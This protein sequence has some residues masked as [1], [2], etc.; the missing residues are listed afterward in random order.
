MTTVINQVNGFVRFFE[1]MTGSF[2]DGPWMEEEKDA[3]IDDASRRLHAW[4]GYSARRNGQGY[5]GH[6]MLRSM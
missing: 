2:S 5:S 6:S 1:L 4:T 3:C